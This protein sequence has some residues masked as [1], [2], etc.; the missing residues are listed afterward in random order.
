MSASAAT[1][2][3]NILGALPVGLGLIALRPMAAQRAA[4]EACGHHDLAAAPPAG[5]AAGMAA[6]WTVDRNV[7]PGLAALTPKPHWRK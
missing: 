2:L 1:T 6:T 4:L 5:E 7:Q 3:R